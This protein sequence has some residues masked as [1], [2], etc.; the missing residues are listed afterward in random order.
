VKFTVYFK[1]YD[2]ELILF[3]FILC[4]STSHA[5]RH[6]SSS[7]MVSLPEGLAVS[8]FSKGWFSSE[9]I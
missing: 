6:I 4:G 3:Y 5:S 2:T 9:G 7:Q 1:F 8:L